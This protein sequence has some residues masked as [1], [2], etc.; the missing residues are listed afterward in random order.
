VSQIAA[1]FT[2]WADE[3]IARVNGL[4]VAMVEAVAGKPR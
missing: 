4:T 2:G 3:E 1:R